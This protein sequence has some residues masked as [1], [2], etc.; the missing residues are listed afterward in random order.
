[1]PEKPVLRGIKIEPYYSPDGMLFHFSVGTGHAGDPL[2]LTTPTMRGALEDSPHLKPGQVLGHITYHG[3]RFEEG[4]QEGA[5]DEEVYPFFNEP[6]IAPKLRRKGIASRLEERALMELKR[7]FGGGLKI[8][9]H[10]NVEE[11]RKRQLAERGIPLKGKD[12]NPFY[13]ATVDE[14]L[15]GIRRARK[16]QLSTKISEAK[17]RRRK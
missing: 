14:M 7:R 10:L 3:Y 16:K 9:P 2:F 15:A 13:S 11:P 6:S 4:R 17:E 1:M 8:H 5:F 12:Y